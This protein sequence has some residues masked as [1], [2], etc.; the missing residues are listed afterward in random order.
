MLC[1]KPSGGSPWGSQPRRQIFWHGI[2]SQ[3]RSS[4]SW[5]LLLE[6]L[7]DNQ[8][9]S[10]P[11][12]LPGFRKTDEC[13]LQT[14]FVYTWAWSSIS[15][16]SNFLLCYIIPTA[17]AP[18]YLHQFKWNQNAPLWSHC[19]L[20]QELTHKT[21]TVT[22]LTKR[23]SKLV[24]VLKFRKCV[25]KQVHSLPIS[26]QNYS[27]FILSTFHRCMQPYPGSKELF[28]SWVMNIMGVSQITNKFAL[29]KI[30]E[31]TP[32]LSSEEGWLLLLN[33]SLV[34][35][36]GSKYDRLWPMSSTIFTE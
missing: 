29:M 32:L 13:I 2:C 18:L 24:S 26:T 11:H 25:S 17:E 1:N 8:G 10:I 35:L 21:I 33:F 5:P 36:V 4:P 27:S 30:Q 6:L 9:I 19:Q 34:V 31:V 15:D 22:I 23:L 16:P 20:R 3:N 12:P 7:L 28:F 14:I